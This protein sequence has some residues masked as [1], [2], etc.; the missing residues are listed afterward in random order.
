MRLRF[1]FIAVNLV[2][3]AI[4]G[5]AVVP[6][7]VSILQGQ[8]LAFRLSERQLAIMEEN[9]RLYKENAALLVKLQSEA[10]Y[11]IQPAGQTGEFLAEIRSS[12]NLHNL[13][14]R[15]FYASEQALHFV[16]GRYIT[17]IQALIA[18]DGNHYDIVYF[19]KDL[20]NH[21]RFI[22]IG[23]LRISEEFSPSRLWLTFSIYEEV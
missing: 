8:Q 11:I 20:A 4:F 22:R 23:R 15:E 12:L 2:V 18:A 3:L 5:W 1:Y 7:Q 21:Y 13:S 6:E 16:D 17:E 19:I 10:S 9:Y 14:E